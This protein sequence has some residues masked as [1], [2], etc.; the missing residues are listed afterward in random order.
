MRENGA[1]YTHAA[2]WLLL[3]WIRMGDAERAH[4]A[5]K[6]L[7]PLNH[8]DTKEKAER[9]RVEPY[10]VAA[11]VY[12]GIHAGRGG[13]TWYTGS[14]GW[15]YQCVL[16]LM[17]FERQ[18]SRV[19][20]NALLGEWPE[21]SITVRWGQARYRLVC[22]ADVVHADC[23]GVVLEDGWLELRDD[24]GVHEAHFP[25]RKGITTETKY[26]HDLQKQAE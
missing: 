11:D 13:W 6:M 3:A 20:M 10:V 23:D 5:L 19:R 26:A 24:G 2:C 22:R 1:Q 12:D 16:E 9:Y 17:G 18:G 4:R 14:A 7:L 25:P 21:A 15:L 8:A